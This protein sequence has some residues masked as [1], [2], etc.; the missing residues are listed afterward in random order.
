MSPIPKD[1]HH[2]AAASVVFPEYSPPPLSCPIPQTRHLF[3]VLLQRLCRRRRL[4]GPVSERLLTFGLLTS[5]F[6]WCLGLIFLCQRLR[7]CRQFP[8][9]LITTP[10]PPSSSPNP[11]RLR[12]RL[13]YLGRVIYLL[14]SS[15]ASVVVVNYVGQSVKDYLPLDC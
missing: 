15:N 9:T 3:I 14:S 13:R 1:P 2:N 8:R 10:Q 4:R 6:F 12:C 11:L 7:S 5:Y